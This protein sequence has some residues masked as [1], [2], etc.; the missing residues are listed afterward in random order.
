MKDFKFLIPRHLLGELP[1]I[2]VPRI[3]IFLKFILCP[4][5][6]SLHVYI[7]KE[8]DS[9]ELGLHKCELPCEFWEIEP[10]SCGKVTSILKLQVFPASE[11]VFF[12][13]VS[14]CVCVF[15]RTCVCH[16]SIEVKREL[17]WI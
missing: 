10:G 6:F 9:L 14:V 12:E 15:E 1:S 3:Y 2:R 5:V 4:L 13:C 8:S 11:M 17:S 7:Y 16:I